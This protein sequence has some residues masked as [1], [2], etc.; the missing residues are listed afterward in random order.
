[1]T[2]DDARALVHVTW[3]A[4][5]ELDDALLV[6]L[7]GDVTGTTDGV[8]VVR[9][10]RTCGSDRHGQPRVVR[11]PGAARV[12]VSLARSGGRAVVAV[13]DVG[14]VGVDVEEGGAAAPH[15]LADWV[16][17]ESLVKATGHGLTIDP[18][19]LDVDRRTVDLAAPAGCVAAVTVLTGRLLDVTTR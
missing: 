8:R 13:T 18:A 17:A 5:A 12:F 7:V 6:R 11:E 14:D 3:V 16:R 1:M 19:T 4:A 10:C 2:P 15:E 9:A